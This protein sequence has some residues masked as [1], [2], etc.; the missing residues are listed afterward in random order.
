MFTKKHYKGI[1]NILKGMSPVRSD[2][3]TANGFEIRAG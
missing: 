2:L 3:E 1:A